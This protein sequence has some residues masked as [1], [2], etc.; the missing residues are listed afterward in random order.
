MDVAVTAVKSVRELRITNAP[1]P[2]HRFGPSFNRSV[3]ISTG[4]G[5]L[6]PAFSA[7]LFLILQPGY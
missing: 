2:E 3:N 7:I 1:F 5:L 4:G 6:W